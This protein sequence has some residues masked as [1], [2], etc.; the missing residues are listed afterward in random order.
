MKRGEPG[1]F[2]FFGLAEKGS[3][4][5]DRL[6][7]TIAECKGN[8][9]HYVDAEI[10]VEGDLRVMRNTFGP[11]DSESEVTVLVKK[12]DKDALLLVLLEALHAGNS[13]TLEDLEK[14]AAAKN[15]PT[16][17]FRWP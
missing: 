12:S 7:I 15:I 6:E 1:I 2:P 17:R 5:A 10:T 13:N 9:S 4:M 8:I 16:N 11:G 14:L 3:Q